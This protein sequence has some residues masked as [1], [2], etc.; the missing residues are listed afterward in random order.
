MILHIKSLSARV[1]SLKDNIVNAPQLCTCLGIKLDTSE[2][3][4]GRKISR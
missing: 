3:G 4:K 1:I 2:K